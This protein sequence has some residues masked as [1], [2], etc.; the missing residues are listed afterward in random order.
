MLVELEGHQGPVTA[1]EFCP[2]QGQILIS[3]SEDRSFKVGWALG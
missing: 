1:A 3:V 2:W